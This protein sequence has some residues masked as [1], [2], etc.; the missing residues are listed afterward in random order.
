[1]VVRPVEHRIAVV[2]SVDLTRRAP[3][4]NSWRGEVRATAMDIIYRFGAENL[5]PAAV[6]ALLSDTYWFRNRSIDQVARTLRHS[7]V[8]SAWAGTRL[9]GFAR[10][11]T[12]FTTHAYLADVVVAADVRGL[13]IGTRM[14]GKL[15]DHEA[16]ATC[17]IHLHTRDAHEVY[18]R[19][20]FHDRPAMTRPRRIGGGWQPEGRHAARADLISAVA[21]LAEMPAEKHGNSQI[22]AGFSTECST[23]ASPPAVPTA[24]A[25]PASLDGTAESLADFYR[26]TMTK[27]LALPG[28]ERSAE[29]FVPSGIAQHAERVADA[30]HR[31]GLPLPLALTVYYAVAGE[32]WLTTHHN[33]LLFPEEL[34]IREGRLVIMEENQV[35]VIWGL[36]LATLSPSSADPLVELRSDSWYSEGLGVSRFLMKMWNF[37]LHGVE[38]EP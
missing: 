30:E 18:R 25:V 27:V 5:A 16:V 24:T 12:D 7:F 35:I 13:G 10:L 15:V 6:H 31:L 32:H 19:L 22:A 14:V 34:Y 36:P 8:M 28:A 33:R 29:L 37:Q 11:I 9:V 20:G 26:A 17:Q 38:A 2:M 3:H 23:G 21:A 4:L 1:M